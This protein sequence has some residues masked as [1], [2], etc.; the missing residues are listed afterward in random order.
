M[1][2]ESL[3]LA[4]LQCPRPLAGFV[5]SPYGSDEGP[6]A[7]YVLKDASLSHYMMTSAV[8]LKVLELVD[9]ERSVAQIRAEL[10]ERWQ[11]RLSSE[12]LCQFLDNCSRNGIVDAES[13]QAVYD[14]QPRATN[15]RQYSSIDGLLQV[16]DAHRRWWW[17][18]LTQG[19]L[20]ALVL[21]GLVQLFRIP[22]GG[23]LLSPL[24]MLTYTPM[25]M[26]LMALPLLYGVEIFFHEM[27]HALTCHHFG[28]RTRG[29]AFKLVWGVFPAVVTDTQDANTLRSKYQRM[30]VSLAG[31]M[32][33][34]MSFGVV[35]TIVQMLDPHSYAARFLLAYSGLSLATLAFSLNPFLIQM[36]GYWV[37]ADWLEQ[38]NLRR[39][40]LR[41]AGA[42]LRRLFGRAPQA[43]VANTAPQRIRWVYVL[44]CLV[45]IAWTTA[46]VLQFGYE[47]GHA[48]QGAFAAPG[49]KA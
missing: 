35:L 31:P 5:A 1:S 21:L 24:H 43:Q 17:N 48:L 25:D 10:A 3:G 40:A 13:W 39:I 11:I 16:L 22:A 9:G 45:A 15:A 37:V 28:A 18:P 8:G 32:V 47:F 44:Y 20:A 26:L 38:P 36:D 6:K 42:A 7:R 33:N 27:A 41:Q 14:T 4:L 29:I 34:L 2:A 12:R 30:A 46:L 49:V 23:G 19:L